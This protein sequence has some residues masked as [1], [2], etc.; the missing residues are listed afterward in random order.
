[1]MKNKILIVFFLTVTSLSGCI[2]DT[3]DRKPLNLISDADVWASAT[4]IDIYM[5][6]LYDNIPI[7]FTGQNYQSVFT[8]EAATVL[9]GGAVLQRNYGNINRFLNTTQYLW[10]RRVNY[11]LDRIKTAAIPADKIQQYSAE[12]RFIRAYYYFDLVKKYGGMPIINE[13][14]DFTGSNLEALK[15]PR[16]TEDEVYSFILEDLNAAIADLPPTWDAKNANRATNIVAQALKSRAMLYAGSI[17]KYGTVQLN[18]LIGIPASKANTYFT[19]SLNASKAVMA[20]NKYSLYDKAYNPVSKTG[21]PVKNY[22]DI[23]LDK[24][25]KEVIFQRAY[26][27]PDKPHSF[28]FENIP[29]AYISSTG[30]SICPL[31]ELVESYEYTDG[32]PGILNVDGKEFDSPDELFKNKDPRFAASI[33]RSGSPFIG[34]PVQMWAGIY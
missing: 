19:E 31:L 28:D 32:T 2:K 10:I 24:N 20:S 34:R 25:N 6:A 1:M 5:A 12:L 21:D 4:M 9:Q 3:L 7:G 18:G 22:T 16:N 30:S 26:T 27:V 13:V 33:F 11:A 8:D 29:I 23:F 15:V 14:Q 17:A